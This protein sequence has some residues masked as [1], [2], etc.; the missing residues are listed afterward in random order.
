[1][2][3]PQWHKL[4]PVPAHTAWGVLRHFSSCH[5]RVWCG[6]KALWRGGC[7]VPHE[8]LAWSQPQDPRCTER[9][10]AAARGAAARFGCSLSHTSTKAAW[11]QP[12]P[13]VC[14]GCGCHQHV[15][16][17]PSLVGWAGSGHGAVPRAMGSSWRRAQRGWRGRVWG[18]P[19][20]RSCSTAVSFLLQSYAALAGVP[21]TAR[22]GAAAVRLTCCPPAGDSPSPP[23]APGSPAASPPSCGPRTSTCP[24]ARPAPGDTRGDT[25]GEGRPAWPRVSPSPWAACSGLDVANQEP[26]WW[27]WHPCPT[28]GSFCKE[29]CST[30][31]GAPHEALSLIHI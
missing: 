20:P 17:T 11:N 22:S 10:R 18:S 2:G 27:L 23:S 12:T 5:T 7:R 16:G 26:S 21:A 19:S 9:R 3:P 14:A 30:P 6:G 28:L 31:R 8:V 15:P 25:F 13:S 4:P 29:P 1:M 24:A